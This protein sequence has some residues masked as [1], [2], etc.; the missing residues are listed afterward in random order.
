MAAETHVRGRSAGLGAAIAIASALALALAPRVAA[1]QACTFDSSLSIAFPTYD[2]IS[3]AGVTSSGSV[4]YRC[5][6][7]QAFEI[8]LSA[9]NSAS[10]RPWREM[11]L[12]GNVPSEVLKY[13]LCLETLCPQNWWDGSG[14][15]SLLARPRGHPN[16]ETVPVIAEIQAAQDPLVGSYSDTVV[17]T[18]I[19]LP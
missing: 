7:N 13:R 9:G 14:G 4:T 12:N 17:M 2:P 1:A 18:V 10:S 15:T 16:R 3:G 19:L 6:R 8:S 11:W 5:G